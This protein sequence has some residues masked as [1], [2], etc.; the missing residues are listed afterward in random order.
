MSSEAEEL[1]DAEQGA[2]LAEESLSDR[3]GRDEAG[4]C[5]NRKNK[6]AP[7][8]PMMGGF[9]VQSAPTSGGLYIPDS[10]LGVS[11]ACSRVCPGC[12][13]ITPLA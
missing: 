7:S 4:S 1:S 2:T 5:R 10:V 13:M 8:A 11:R 6:T 3:S 9:H 12:E